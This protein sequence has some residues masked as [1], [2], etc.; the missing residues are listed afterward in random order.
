LIDYDQNGFVARSRRDNLR[1]CL[2]QVYAAER[3]RQI[4][5]KVVPMPGSL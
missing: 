5:R 1:H 2:D 4:G 3:V